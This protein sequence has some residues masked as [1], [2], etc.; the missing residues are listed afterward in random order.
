MGAGAGAGARAGIEWL[1]HSDLARDLPAAPLE[2]GLT[3][4]HF[5]AQ[6]EPFLTQNTLRT[7]PDTPSYPLTHPKHPLNNPQMHP[8]PTECAEVEPKS[9]RV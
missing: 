4:V 7:T 8:Y 6:P 2:Q 1:Y 5:S 3:L 9:G